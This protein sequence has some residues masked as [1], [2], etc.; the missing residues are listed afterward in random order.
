MYRSLDPEA[1]LKETETLHQRITERFE[2]GIARSAPMSQVARRPR[3]RA[4]LIARP[5]W[6][7]RIGIGALILALVL[8]FISAASTIRVEVN[9]TFDLVEFLAILDAGFNDLFLIGAVLFFLIRLEARLKRNK[10]L[11]ALH[12]LRSLAHVIDMHQLTKDPERVTRKD[13]ESTP[14][15]P[16]ASMSP[17]LLMRYL[18]YCSEMLSILGKIAS[19]YVQNFNDE[20][21]LAAVDEIEG[22]DE[23]PVQEDLA[24][25][26]D[27]AREHSAVIQ[28]Q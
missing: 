2:R 20:A 26:H 18:D 14:S 27:P 11:A 24:E 13:W 1:I 3:K 25:D 6:W 22:L 19:L 21:A 16:R 8:I 10:A 17:F 9:R 15:S 4:A 28:P 23:R 12:E 5:N 7:L